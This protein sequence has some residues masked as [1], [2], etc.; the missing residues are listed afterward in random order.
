M[1]VGFYAIENM[2]NNFLASTIKIGEKRAE[3]LLFQ[4]AIPKGI[5]DYL[6]VAFQH[7]FFKHASPVGTDGGYTQ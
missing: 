1:V 7:H 2:A 3:A 6:G 5:I 4:Q